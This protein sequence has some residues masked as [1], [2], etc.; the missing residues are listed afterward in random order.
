M[1]A[2]SYLVPLPFSSASSRPILLE[3]LRQ[4]P[5]ERTRSRSLLGL[6]SREAPR[7]AVVTPRMWAFPAPSGRAEMHTPWSEA[8]QARLCRRPAFLQKDSQADT[9]SCVC[10]RSRNAGPLVFWCSSWVVECAA[11]SR[12]AAKCCGNRELPL[13]LRAVLGSSTA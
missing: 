2:S 1:S 5:G 3:L 10:L 6:E 9:E 8:A 4:S 7:Q 11:R 12:V 13:S